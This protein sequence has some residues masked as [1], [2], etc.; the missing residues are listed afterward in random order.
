MCVHNYLNLT[1]IITSTIYH[2]SLL[3]LDNV[4]LH[5]LCYSFFLLLLYI[6]MLDII[7]MTREKKEHP[8]FIHFQ[9]KAVQIKIF[10]S[11]ACFS[12]LALCLLTKTLTYN[13]QF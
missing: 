6:I 12:A 2:F 3:L 13:N 7:Q 4:M 11:L 8:F 9:Q 10:S 1:T 5:I